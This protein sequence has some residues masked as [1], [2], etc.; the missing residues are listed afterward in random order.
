MAMG[1]RP[2]RGMGRARVMVS[3]GMKKAAAKRLGIFAARA[4]KPSRRQ[5]AGRPRGREDVPERITPRMAMDS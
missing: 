4:G 3:P 1:Q 5:A 2:L